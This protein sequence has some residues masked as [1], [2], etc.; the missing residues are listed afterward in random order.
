MPEPRG[1]FSPCKI[2]QFPAIVASDVW[3]FDQAVSRG[4]EFVL[5][6]E[7]RL[8]RL[9]FFSVAW[10]FSGAFISTTA[11]VA[12]LDFMGHTSANSI[13]S[14]HNRLLVFSTVIL[15]FTLLSQ[16]LVTFTSTLVQTP[17]GTLTTWGSSHPP[18]HQHR[19]STTPQT[20]FCT[21]PSTNTCQHNHQ[22]ITAVHMQ[23][24]T[25]AQRPGNAGSR[26]T[27]ARECLSHRVACEIGGCTG[28]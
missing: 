28:F 13:Y 8:H 27:P 19:P 26:E 14:S 3:L 21:S 11:M 1:Q 17:H 2:R 5:E 24:L 6:V 12:N 9:W 25:Q 18:R 16:L 15:I 4:T 22:H 10:E 20:L 7:Y 23:G